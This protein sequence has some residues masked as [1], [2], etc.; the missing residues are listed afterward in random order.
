[1]NIRIGEGRL[2]VNV[3][4]GLVISRVTTD[5]AVAAHNVRAKPDARIK[6][7]DQ[8]VTVNGVQLST[9]TDFRQHHSSREVMQLTLRRGICDQQA[10][11]TALRTGARGDS[12]ETPAVPMTRDG[13]EDQVKVKPSEQVFEEALTS[14]SIPPACTV[15]DKTLEATK[16]M[17]SAKS[18]KKSRRDTAPEELPIDTSADPTRF[19]W[20]AL[21]EKAADEEPAAQVTDPMEFEE[22][23]E[24]RALL[25]RVLLMGHGCVSVKHSTVSF[26]S[27]LIRPLEE[28]LH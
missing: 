9:L 6:V 10:E 22:V 15:Q 26:N 1:M 5:G 21:P 20:V 25:N 27:P 8:I 4:E 11:V 12:S 13:K 23:P 3:N 17:K 2:G 18:A 24:E 7:G 14:G 16:T 28:L 19:G